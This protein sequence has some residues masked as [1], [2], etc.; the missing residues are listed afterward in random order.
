MEGLGYRSHR[1]TGCPHQ[2]SALIEVRVLEMWRYTPFWGPRRLALELAKKGL[3]PT[4]SAS[5]IYRCLLR[6]ASFRRL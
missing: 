2:M 5:A 6:G 4:P 3:T 1:P